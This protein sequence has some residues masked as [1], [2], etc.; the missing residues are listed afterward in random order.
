MNSKNWKNH[1]KAEGKTINVNLITEE[2]YKGDVYKPLNDFFRL[3]EYEISG[4]QT[5]KHGFVSRDELIRHGFEGNEI[6]PMPYMV[7]IEL[8]KLNEKVHE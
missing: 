7:W 8:K 3:K 1:L 2:M 6:I 4:F 5:E